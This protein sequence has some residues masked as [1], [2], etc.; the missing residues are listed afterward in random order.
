MSNQFRTLLGTRHRHHLA[1]EE[2]DTTTAA[3]D[4]TPPEQVATEDTTVVMKG[5]LADVYSDA[6]SKVYDKDVAPPGDPAAAAEPASETGAAVNTTDLTPVV[7]EEQNT[8]EAAIFSEVS[9]V[10]LES[11]AIDAAVASSLAAAIADAPPADGAA[12]Q[13]LY[14]ID[15]TQVKPDDVK[16]V[17]AI[18]AEADKPENVTVLIDSVVPDSVLDAADPEVTGSKE[19]ALGLES[20]VIAMGGNVVHSFKDYLASRPRKAT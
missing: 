15:E 20:I 7:P 9:Q 18:L 16:D 1:I 3:P 14:A 11:Q 17:T 10:V 13:T 2:I 4:G 5:P 8:V 19:L 12:Y 6:L